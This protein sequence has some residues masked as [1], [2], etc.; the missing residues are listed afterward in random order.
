MELGEL[1]E[2]GS[3]MDVVLKVTG[4][5]CVMLE[6]SAPYTHAVARPLRFTRTKA[7]SEMMRFHSPPTKL[8]TTNGPYVTKNA[9][10]KQTARSADRSI[11]VSPAAAQDLNTETT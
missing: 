8:Y 5:P 6:W 9:S 11:V 1:G 10:G 7:T 3:I 2:P 4:K